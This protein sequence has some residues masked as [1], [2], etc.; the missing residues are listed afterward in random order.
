MAKTSVYVG[1]QLRLWLANTSSSLKQAMA[2]S[3]SNSKFKK[4]LTK[5]PVK[6]IGILW[7]NQNDVK[8]YVQEFAKND[9]QRKLIRISFS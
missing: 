8:R 1:V 9:N 3:S 2:T 5:P 7:R 6:D 4:G